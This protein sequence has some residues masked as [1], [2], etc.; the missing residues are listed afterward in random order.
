MESSKV[1]G[2][3]T[4]PK[5]DED[6]RICETM[7]HPTNDCPTI[8][9]FKEVLHYQANFMNLVKISY[10]SPYLDTYNLGWRNHPNFNWRDDNVAVPSTHGSLNFVP[11]YPP[12]KKSL[13]DTLQQFMQTQSTINN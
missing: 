2:V 12:P 3:N 8:P 5:I 4:V 6:C 10:P 1:N 9:A 13:E 11:Y 7:E